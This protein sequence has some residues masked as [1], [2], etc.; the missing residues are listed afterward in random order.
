[1]IDILATKDPKKDV[2]IVKGPKD[3]SS[4]RFTA[5]LYTRVLSNGEKCDRDWLVNSKMFDRVFCFCCKFF[6]RGIGIG[7][8][9]NEG[10]YTWK[11]VSERLRE[12]EVGME[13]V[14][15]ITTWYEFRK[16]MQNFQTIDKPT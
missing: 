1:M 2:S 3:K 4:R 13:Y 8:L 9:A 16:G 7:Q 5:N 12:H 14:H 11:H 10:F 15:N 6:K